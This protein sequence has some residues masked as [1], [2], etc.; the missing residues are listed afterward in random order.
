VTNEQLLYLTYFGAAAGGAI[1]AAGTAL[2]L[3]RPLR[4]ALRTAGA[5]KFLARFFP[6]WLILAVLLG[7]VSVNYLECR[8]YNSVINDRQYIIDKSQE[9]VY[10]IALLLKIAL[11]VYAVIVIPHLWAAA[12]SLR[13]GRKS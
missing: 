7:F 6:T 5:G 9:L 4:Q 1:L 3:N 12:K 10:R 11:F 13:S 2:L 8:D